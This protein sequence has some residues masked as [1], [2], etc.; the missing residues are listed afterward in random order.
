MVKICSVSLRLFHFE[1]DV[2]AMP[3]VS[4]WYRKLFKIGDK[5]LVEK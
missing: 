5:T 3:T 1:D 2:D 4:I